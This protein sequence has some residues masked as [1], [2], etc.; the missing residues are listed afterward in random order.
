MISAVASGPT[1]I[2]TH[3]AT[4]GETTAFYAA[5]PRITGFETLADPHCYRPLPDDWVLGLA[6]VVKSTEAIQA[7]RYRAV[8]TAGAA[9][10]AAVSN[11][12]GAMDFPYV[13]A[14]DGMGYAVPPD[15]AAPARQAL[16]SSIAWVGTDLNLT[17]RGGE[18][19]VASIRA[20]GHEIRVAR[21][22]PSPDVDYAMFS[23]GGLLWAEGQLKA[24]GLTR[25]EPDPSRRPDLTGLSCRFN[26]VQARHGLML[27]VIVSPRRHGHDA[28]FQAL[29]TALIDLIDSRP[30]AAFPIRE[31]ALRFPWPPGGF[32]DEVRLQRKDGQSWLSSLLAVGAWTTLSALV[33]KAGRDLRGFSPAAYRKQLVANSDHRKFEDRLMMTIDCSPAVADAIEDLLSRSRQEG[34]ADFG[35]QRQPSALITCVVPSPTRRDH[36]HFI[37]GAAGGYALA[38]LELK[39]SRG[40]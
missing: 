40:T 24:G 5:L 13:F 39:T 17:L 19:D 32:A 16:A 8:N 26:P 6:D 3:A 21:F 22:A 27:S 31:N 30:D 38:A 11:A 33:F 28:A 2:A 10:I 9:V 37:D 7:G 18:I 14:G 1:N 25:V 15:R 35:V 23:G 20:S 36:V 29:V 34:V 12:V 4:P